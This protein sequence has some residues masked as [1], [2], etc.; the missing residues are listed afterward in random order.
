MGMT[1]EEAI[2]LVWDFEEEVIRCERDGY[3]ARDRR[4]REAARGRLL[5]ALSP[6]SDRKT[7]AE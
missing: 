4:D 6:T 7:G 3:K 5:D 1:R 2:N